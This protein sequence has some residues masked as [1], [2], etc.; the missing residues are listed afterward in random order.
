MFPGLS[1]VLPDLG[2]ARYLLDPVGS[3]VNDE[4]QNRTNQDQ[5][6]KEERNRAQASAQRVSNIQGQQMGLANNFQANKE[7]Y[8]GLLQDQN[9]KPL[10]MQMSQ[11]LADTKLDSSRRGLLGSGIDQRKRADVVSQYKTDYG[12]AMDS[13]SNQFSNLESDV[14][15]APAKT[16]LELGGL[17]QSSQEDYYRAALNDMQGRNSALA[18]LGSGLGQLGGS[19]LANRKV[20]GY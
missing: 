1:S 14:M 20:D 10:R 2:S 9:V 13:A 7:K 4:Y 15:D 18:G 3:V 17:N 12:T 6:E 5:R 11:K 8:R 16:G 19:Y